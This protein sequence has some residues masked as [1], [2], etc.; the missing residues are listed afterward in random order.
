[1]FTE[2]I[3]GEKD[4]PE[5]QGGK[6]SGSDFERDQTLYA[7]ATSQ[8]WDEG[9]GKFSDTP[10]GENGGDSVV[11]GGSKTLTADGGGGGRSNDNPGIAFS[12][13]SGGGAGWNNSNFSGGQATQASNTTDGVNTY[14]GTGFGSA[15][16]SGQAASPYYGAGGGA[17]GAGETGGG[18]Q[19]GGVGK[20]YSTELGT[21]YGV[22]GWFAGNCVLCRS[23]LTHVY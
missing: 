9:D 4:K 10:Q 3:G 22:S 19:D 17:G 7:Y 16:G 21:T 18:G 1:M 15:G 6:L 8:S 13:G 14:N 20:D 11:A 12:G 2:S 5:P 23:S